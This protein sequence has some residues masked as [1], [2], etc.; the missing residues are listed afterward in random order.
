MKGKGRE[1]KK[2]YKVEKDITMKSEEEG[3][4]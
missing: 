3:E 2:G 1:N 4:E